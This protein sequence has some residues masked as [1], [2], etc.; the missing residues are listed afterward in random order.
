MGVKVTD[1][2]QLP[3]AGTLVPQLSVSAKSPLIVS[4]EIANVALPMLRRRAVCGWLVEPTAWAVYRIE[5]GLMDT[6]GA[7]VGSI[8]ITKALAVP[9][10]VFWKAADVTGKSVDSV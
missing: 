5:T 9:A 7:E 3:A 4:D 10:S 2:V 8:F 6:D 1:S